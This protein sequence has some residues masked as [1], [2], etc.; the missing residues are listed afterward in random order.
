MDPVG[1]FI[2]RLVGPVSPSWQARLLWRTAGGERAAQSIVNAALQPGDVAL[3]VGANIGLYTDRFARLVGRRGLVYA[4]EPNP[5]YSRGLTRIASVRKN[6]TFV[7]AA[8]SDRSGKAGLSVPAAEAGPN[9]SMGSLEECAAAAA[10]QTIEVPTTTLDAQIGSI[11]G[12]RLL[13]CDVEGHEHEVLLGGLELL[14]RERP[15]LLIEIEQR[16]RRRPVF[17][18]F[19]LC[20]ELAYDGYM[21]TAGGPRPLA[22]FNLQRDQVDVIADDPST[23]TPRARYINNFLF[24]PADGNRRSGG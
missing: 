8:L 12:I 1:A 5:H 20:D 7:A 17:E 11:S 3:D 14:R 13:K 22:D 23:A 9:R 18:T 21:L 6:V 4:F 19:D 15:I 10:V 2:W 24:M 16:H